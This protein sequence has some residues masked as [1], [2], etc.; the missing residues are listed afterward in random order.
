MEKVV[1]IDNSVWNN[2]Q[3]NNIIVEKVQSNEPSLQ[4]YKEDKK[5][6]EK[7]YNRVIGFQEVS[8]QIAL[9]KRLCEIKDFPLETR[10]KLFKKP[11]LFFKKVIMRLFRWIFHGYISQQNAFNKQLISTIETINNLQTYLCE[12]EDNF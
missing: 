2:D 4:Y 11:A 9:L 10:F 1:V 12:R 8:N 7:I 5:E 6:P 3:L